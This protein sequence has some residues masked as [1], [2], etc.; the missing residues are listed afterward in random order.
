[1]EVEEAVMRILAGLTAMF[2][3]C[4]GWA[5][6]VEQGEPN[7]PEFSPAF[8]GQTRAE[9]LAPTAIQVSVFARGLE[10]PW[11]IAALPGGGY[12][13]TERPGRMRIVGEDGR[14]S[15]PI[16][17]LPEVAARQQGGL[18]DVALSPG[19]E[20]DRR[21]YWTY[22]KPVRGG[23]VTAAARGVLSQDGTRMSEIEEIFEQA[24]PRR[25]GLHF[26]SRILFG[27]EG[28][29]FITVGERFSARARVL[30]Q[31]LGATYGKVV[32]LWPDGR[33]PEDNPYGSAV[34]S[35]GHRNPQGAA[36]RPGD[37]ALLTI[38]HGPA[39][40]DELNRIEKGANYGWPVISYGENYDGSPVGEGRT[41]AAGMEQ[42]LYYWDPVI[43]PSG[44]AFYDGELFADWRGD[45][46]I[47]SLNPGGLVRLRL[48][49]DRVVG[50]ER[51][52]EGDHR[53]R[54]VEVA[55]DGAVLLLVD[56]PK[57]GIFRLVPR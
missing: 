5:A 25:N 1:M 48:Q 15:A 55:P 40:G 22:A 57:G 34:W 3:G 38:E 18:L 45:L 56:A 49:G 52:I 53:I 39:G 36:V 17:G 47:A 30:A 54:D 20:R 21:V 9:A 16:E 32:R 46:L 27:P 7:V 12:L 43:A 42:P 51:M 2:M 23:R 44:M 26:G 41:Q 35:Y 31:D 19:F 28:H 8:E 14:V 6:P 10:H 50:E 11:G 13:V 37:G 33:V 4:A 24:P 29:V